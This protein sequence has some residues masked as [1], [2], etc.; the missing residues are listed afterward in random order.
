MQLSTKS[1]YATRAMIELAL[2]YGN[3]HIQLKEIARRQ[4]ISDKYLEQVL[5]PLR[6]KGF[7]YT[8]KGNRGGYSLAKPPE[9]ITLYDIINNVEGSLAPTTCVDYEDTCDRVNVCVTR[10]VWA[11]L[12]NRLTEELNA[13]TLAELAEEQK[14]KYAEVSEPTAYQI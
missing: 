3:G 7:V 1:R 9:Q 11:K 13:I 8:Q 10:D 4:N 6:T 12:K 2:N 14:R 5:F